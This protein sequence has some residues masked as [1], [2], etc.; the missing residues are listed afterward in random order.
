MFGCGKG[1]ALAAAAKDTTQVDI[2]FP[3]LP[4][5]GVPGRIRFG[6][7]AVPTELAFEQAGIAEI[8]A[9]GGA[10]FDEIAVTLMSRLMEHPK[11][12]AKLRKRFAVTDEVAHEQRF[13][14]GGVAD[15]AGGLQEIGIES[16]RRAQPDGGETCRS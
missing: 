3:V 1:H 10:E 13:I 8:D 11:V 4:E 5:R 7:Y 15:Q 2:R 14:V 9:V 6:Q 12:L 16:S